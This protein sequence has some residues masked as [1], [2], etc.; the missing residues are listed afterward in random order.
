[1][2][3]EHSRRLLILK[4]ANLCYRE[5]LTQVPGISFAGPGSCIKAN[6]R[7]HFASCAHE[8]DSVLENIIHSRENIGHWMTWMFSAITI[9]DIIYCFWLPCKIGHMTYHVFC[10]TAKGCGC[11]V[12]ET[13][14]CC[15]GSSFG[16][17]VEDKRDD[18]SF[19]SDTVCVFSLG[20]F[21]DFLLA[22]SIRSICSM[23][24]SVFLLISLGSL[25][26]AWLLNGGI[27]FNRRLL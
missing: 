18:G 3:S 25:L 4:L 5:T 7:K 12:L 2:R 26:L 9:P 27:S 21:R 20:W 8:H 23:L 22:C 15:A 10:Y 16:R 11:K 13:T 19:H 24:V 14:W 17:S 6:S 1:M